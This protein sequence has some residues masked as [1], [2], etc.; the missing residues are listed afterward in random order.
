M[1]PGKQQHELNVFADD[2]LMYLTNFENSTHPLL[3]IISEY[4]FYSGYKM[5]IGRQK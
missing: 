2:L 4:L 1:S 3:K 5:Y